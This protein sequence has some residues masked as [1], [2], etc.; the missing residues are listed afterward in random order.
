MKIVGFLRNFLRSLNL[1]F[2]TYC[3]ISSCSYISYYLRIDKYFL[4][5]SLS[6]VNQQIIE[7]NVDSVTLDRDAYCF[8]SKKNIY[9]PGKEEFVDKFRIILENQNLKRYMDAFLLDR[10]VDFSFIP[11]SYVDL[12]EVFLLLSIWALISNMIIDKIDFLEEME[13]KASGKERVTFDDIIGSNEI[14]NEVKGVLRLYS[15]AAAKSLKMKRPKGVLFFGPPGNG[16]TMIA[17]AIATEFEG[18]FFY[19]SASELMEIYIGVGPKKI[20]DVFASAKKEEFAVIFIDEIDA[21]AGGRK[22]GMGNSELHNTLNQLLVEM[23]GIDTSSRILVIGATNL[24]DSFDDA[25]KR[26]FELEIDFNNPSQDEIIELLRY[27]LKDIPSKN[28]NI[29]YIASGLGDVSRAN[30]VS[31]VENAKRIACANNRFYL[32]SEDLDEAALRHDMGKS[33]DYMKLMSD[34]RWKTA[35]HEAGHAFLFYYH[36]KGGAF[37][38]PPRYLTIVPRSYALGFVATPNTDYYQSK[39]VKYISSMMQVCYA[40]LEAE[41]MFCGTDG[42]SIGC[43]SDL[44]QARLLAEHYVNFGLDPHIGYVGVSRRDSLSDNELN[45]KFERVKVI[46]EENLIKTREILE[47]NRGIIEVVARAAIHFG[48]LDQETLLGIIEGRITD[49]S[50]ALVPIKKYNFRL[51][52]NE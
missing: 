49:S 17:K 32:I 34:E 14:K 20:R 45:E 39:T 8:K 50:Y 33:I 3:V 21:I 25:L 1:G 27:L 42:S 29:E 23:D 18:S 13:R 2:F 26:R 31:I 16:K 19:I 40:G 44:S 43:S 52:V 30:I 35:Y 36:Y 7:K 11:S 12:F 22:H 28:I 51:S 48:Y 46:C 47:N 24:K 10:S 4:T 15:D 37:L 38:N 41:R 9:I 6:F 5:D